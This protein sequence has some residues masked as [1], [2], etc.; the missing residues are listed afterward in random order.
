MTTLQDAIYADHPCGDI[1]SCDIARA[2]HEGF[3]IAAGFLLIGATETYNIAEFFK[4]N[5]DKDKEY[6]DN[7]DAEW[8]EWVQWHD[9][10]GRQ[11][12]KCEAINYPEDVTRWQCG[13]CLAKNACDHRNV[14]GTGE[15]CEVEC[16][17]CMAIGTQPADNQPIE[18]EDE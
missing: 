3:T 17:D 15:P 11:C 1:E 13:N 4:E 10:H 7:F 8:K 6:K 18:W 9:E 16:D 2:L 12:N 14:S 5:P